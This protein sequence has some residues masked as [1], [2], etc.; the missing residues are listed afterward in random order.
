MCTQIP[1]TH[2][3]WWEIR[4]KDD[5]FECDSDI[6]CINWKT[7]K[8]VKRLAERND[9]DEN[10]DNDKE[11]E[12]GNDVSSNNG[13]SVCSMNVIQQEMEIEAMSAGM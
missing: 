5:D 9:K 10:S 8:D 12:G 4:D 6:D 2:E 3:E 11:E 7:K 13:Y 1:R